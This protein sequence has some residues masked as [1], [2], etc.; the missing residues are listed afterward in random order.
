MVDVVEE[1]VDMSAVSAHSERVLPD[2]R[3]QPVRKVPM[4]SVNNVGRQLMRVI[5]D[6]GN[7]NSCW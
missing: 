6:I 3:T 4:S 2:G 1:G 7:V 5:N